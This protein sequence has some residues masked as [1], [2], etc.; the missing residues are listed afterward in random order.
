MGTNVGKKNVNVDG[1]FSRDGT[2]VCIWGDAADDRC[3][4]RH[5]AVPATGLLVLAVCGNDPDVALNPLVVAVVENEMKGNRF[6]LKVPGGVDGQCG[7]FVGGIA[8][9]IARQAAFWSD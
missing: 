6:P 3:G 8:L 7:R 4:S 5:H 1:D 2:D 9:D